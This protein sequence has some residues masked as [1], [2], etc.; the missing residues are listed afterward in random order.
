MLTKPKPLPKEPRSKPK[1][2]PKRK[3]VTIAAG[4]QCAEGVIIC[5]DSQETITDVAGNGVK[6]NAPKLIIRPAWASE[7]NTEP[8]AVFAGSGDGDLVDHLTDEIWAGMLRGGKTLEGMLASAQA[9]LHKT[10]KALTGSYH[11]GYLPEVKFLVAVWVPPRDVELIKIVGPVITRYAALDAIGCG[12]LLSTYIVSRLA[13]HKSSFQE[14]IPASLYMIEE[15]KNYVSGCGG[16][17][18]LCTLRYDGTLNFLRKE[19]I[20]ES[21][22]TIREIEQVARRIVAFSISRND[23]PPEEFAR[24]LDEAVEE[25]KQLRAKGRVPN[26]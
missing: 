20:E 10:Y 22:S 14:A 15:V 11:A 19:E 1:R 25:I 2:L 18:H 26:E 24:Y 13:W 16:D 23:V 7:K 5:A 4:F 6:R 17:T 21:V 12:T 3:V 8:C 9:K